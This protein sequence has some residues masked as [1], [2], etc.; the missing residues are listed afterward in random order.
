MDGIFNL[1]EAAES[2]FAPPAVSEVDALNKKRA[3]GEEIESARWPYPAVEFA[4][5]KTL[6]EIDWQELAD[7]RTNLPQS[8]ALEAKLAGFEKT[9]LELKKKCKNLADV[10]ANNPLPS[11]VQRLG[12][13]EE[14][15][16]QA[17][18]QALEKKK[19]L[20][21]M[22]IS[23][24][25]LESP[26]SIQ[27]IAHD[28]TAREVRLELRAEIARRV[29]SIRL[30]RK[31]FIEQKDKRERIK[32]VP[33]FFISIDFVN[34]HTRVIQVA[35]QKGKEPLV[36]SITFQKKQEVGVPLSECK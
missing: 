24:R 32:N 4:I 14:K 8:L 17:V 9:A 33:T 31:K 19:E 18:A 10:I 16:K 28:P 3:R 21:E 5:L 25:E 35:L 6:E 15:R 29:K 30:T 34:G 11:L 27:Q 26:L 13:L 36:Q 12:E 22:E 1:L 7:R 23:H 20:A 2:S